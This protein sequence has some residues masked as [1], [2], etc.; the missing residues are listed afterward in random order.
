MITVLTALIAL[1]MF[2]FI[3]ASLAIIAIC[4]RNRQIDKEIAIFNEL[5]EEHSIQVY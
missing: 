2:I 4:F 3:S 1:T 5:I